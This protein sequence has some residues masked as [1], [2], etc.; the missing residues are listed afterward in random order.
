MKNNENSLMNQELI[1]KDYYKKLSTEMQE[2]NSDKLCEATKKVEA[3]FD[4][5]GCKKD[6]E[7]IMMRGVRECLAVV[8]ANMHMMYT[9]YKS[10]ANPTRELILEK[11]IND[12]LVLNLCTC[13]ASLLVDVKNK[14]IE[15]ILKYI[16]DTYSEA[17]MSY[18]DFYSRIKIIIFVIYMMLTFFL[19]FIYIQLLVWQLNKD[20]LKAKKLLALYPLHQI[21]VNVKEFKKALADLS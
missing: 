12:S 19:F 17:S 21:N 1:L 2:F 18:L 3:S 5:E 15:T 4:V 8:V 14:Y 20:I 13:I 6:M 11:Y 10:E 16:S 9:S 7:E